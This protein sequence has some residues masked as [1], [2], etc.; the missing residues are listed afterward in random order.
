[1][2]AHGSKQAD[3]NAGSGMKNANLASYA[4]RYKVNRFLT[5][6]QLDRKTATFCIYCAQ[7]R[8]VTAK[9]NQ[10]LAPSGGDWGFFGWNTVPKDATHVVITEANSIRIYVLNAFGNVCNTNRENTMQ[11]Q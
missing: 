5:Q 4:V 11:W 3:I 6:N 1:M 9:K 8:S 10:R 7:I 2:P